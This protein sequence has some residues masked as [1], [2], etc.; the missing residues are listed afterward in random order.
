LICTRAPFGC[1][2]HILKNSG[3]PNRK[4][5]IMW[6]TMLFLLG[7]GFC[8]DHEKVLSCKLD[9]WKWTCLVAK[10]LLIAYR[11]ID[12]DVLCRWRVVC[13]LLGPA[14]KARMCYSKKHLFRLK[15]NHHRGGWPVRLG[16]NLWHVSEAHRSLQECAFSTSV[17]RNIFMGIFREPNPKPRFPQEMAGLIIKG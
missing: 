9:R 14:T 11:P 8:S 1:I 13:T 12:V 17:E 16:G 6:E 10:L 4:V 3:P 2:W 7:H 15:K 5:G